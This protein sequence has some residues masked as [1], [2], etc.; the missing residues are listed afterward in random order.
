VVTGSAAYDAGLR[1]G[2]EIV[3][4]VPQDG[5]Q[6]D[7][8]QRLTLK[9]RRIDP[10]GNHADLTFSITYLPRGDTVDA[11]QWQRV[12]DVPDDQCPL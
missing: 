9:L 3:D 10:A 2:D 11:Y 1:N 6:G 7:Q 5:I 12:A 4:P 8:D